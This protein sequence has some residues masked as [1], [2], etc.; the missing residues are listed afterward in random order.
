MLDMLSVEIVEMIVHALEDKTSLLAL[1]CVSRYLCKATFALFA[2]NWFTTLVIDFTPRSLQRL[3]NISKS[4]DLKSR[5]RCLLVGDCYRPPVVGPLGGHGDDDQT[6]VLGEGHTW[7][8]LES[9]CLDLE[10]QPTKDF[11]AALRGFTGCTEICVTDDLDGETDD[12]DDSTSTGLSLAD[13]C[14]IMLSL[15]GTD[16][17]LQIPSFAFMF[18]QHSYSA[19]AERLSPNLVDILTQSS[20][21]SHLKNL[22][23][24]WEVCTETA[25]STMVDLITTAGRLKSLS[26][27]HMLFNNGVFQQLADAPQVPALT[28]LEILDLTAISP[29]VISNAIA[30]FQLSLKS[31]RIKAVKM[32]NHG[33]FDTFLKLLSDQSLPALESV[34]I[35]DCL[36]VFFCPIRLKQSTMEQY[37]GV[38]EFV[39]KGFR[40][41][42]R[43]SGIRYRGSGEGMRL[44]LRTIRDSTRDKSWS[45]FSE[46]DLPVM[47]SHNGERAWHTVKRLL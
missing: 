16:G 34:T 29:S 40:R 8:R 3:S 18:E 15:L 46:S 41:K 47:F 43:V 9:G 2:T 12:D 38:L 39:L 27:R 4:Q 35:E 19:L 10:S 20:W 7:P 45:V 44:A 14:Y 26:F 13:T 37:G 23:I 6:R 22:E 33:E 32:A 11:S 36:N 21:S 24:T 42:A 30:R 17:G 5:V 31:L 28:K 1:R 25:N